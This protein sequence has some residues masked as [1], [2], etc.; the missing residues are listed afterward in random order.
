MKTWTDEETKILVENYPRATNT[1]LAKLLPNKSA[2]GIYK[3]AY[4]MGFRKSKE[5]T[6]ANRSQARKGEKTWNWKGGKYKTK[7]G[8]VMINCPG[9]HRADP[10]GYVLEHILIWEKE[11]GIPVSRDCCIHHLN[12]R[13]DDNRIENLA[14]MKFSAHTVFHHK[15]SKRSEETKRKISEKRRLYNAKRSMHNGQGVQ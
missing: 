15:G 6:F 2:E 5:V 13:K 12:G 14:L 1:E 11:T 10:S 9:H 4:K 3:K 8:Y 7:K